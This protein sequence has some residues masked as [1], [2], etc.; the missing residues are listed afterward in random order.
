MSRTAPMNRLK[1]LLRLSR[2]ARKV[3]LEAEDL[4]ERQNSAL[5]RGLPEQGLLKQRL[6]RRSLLQGGASLALL[7]ACGTAAPPS[8]SGALLEA[9]SV[10]P[11]Q[12]TVIVGAGI[13][14][15]SAAYKLRKAGFYAEIFEAS[16]RVGGRMYSAQNVFGLGEFID[17]GAELV[18]TD[19]TTIRRLCREMDLDLIDQD[20]FEKKRGLL[21]NTWFFGGRSVTEAR[22]LELLSPLVPFIED[23]LT[24]IGSDYTYTG[25]N[26]YA[27]ALDQ[28][29]MLEWLDR[30]RA[31]PL[32]KSLWAETFT[33]DG[34]Q[35]A[36]KISALYFV[37]YV[38]TESK[39]FS[40][41]LSDERFR[42][43]GG[44]SGLTSRLARVLESQITLSSPLSALGQTSSGRYLLTL[45][46]RSVLA[47]RVIL[48][49]PFTTLREVDLRLPLPAIKRRV[50][51]E[52]PY[53]VNAKLHLGFSS[54]YWRTLGAS[55]TSDTDVGYQS[56]WDTTRGQNV[57][58]AVLL[59]WTGASR[60]LEIGQ[61][62]PQFQ[63]ER[64]LPLLEQVYPG[65]RAAYS[66]QAQRF[67]WP[68]ERWIKASYSTNQIGH[69]TTLGGS[70]GEAVGG[71]HF[72]GEHTSLDYQGFMEGG[73]E[74]GERAAQE[75]LVALGL[76]KA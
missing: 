28:I 20:A 69:L 66:G 59:N 24:R 35:D 12:K 25:A 36:S 34:G 31:D 42:I 15:L 11:G 57:P 53:G 72:C 64:F 16:S 58:G 68:K 74:S 40:P 26:A 8:G 23:A 22:L 19:H 43:Q 9:Q 75:V 45:G 3:G 30:Q 4:P 5:E 33:Q 37:T 17:W 27:K 29:S 55:G 21:K 71:L 2:D 10:Q 62:T 61:G 67:Y 7:T 6:S 52:M 41:Y 44:S 76:A 39:S 50:I 63:A 73:A 1:Q 47:D 60:T 32:L 38:S 46:G 14:G 54:P 65:A 48:A 49:L 70:E 56:T 18:N 13:A 51:G